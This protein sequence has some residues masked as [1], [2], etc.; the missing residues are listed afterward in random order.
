MPAAPKEDGLSRRIGQSVRSNSGPEFGTTFLSAQSEHWTAESDSTNYDTIPVNG[1]S[2][3]Q[4][5]YRA[6]FLA[7]NE[8]SYAVQGAGSLNVPNFTSDPRAAESAVPDLSLG[9]FHSHSSNQPGFYFNAVDASQQQDEGLNDFAQTHPDKED[10]ITSSSSSSKHLQVPRGNSRPASTSLQPSLALSAAGKVP[11]RPTTALLP[12]SL[13]VKARST[14]SSAVPGST[15]RPARWEKQTDSNERMSNPTPLRGTSGH[16]SADIGS[17]DELANKTTDSIS[18]DA[19][20]GS[21]DDVEVNGSEGGMG[22]EALQR[23]EPRVRADQPPGILQTG[24]TE[25]AQRTQSGLPAEKVFPIQIGSELFRL[26]GA[27]I[28]SD[29]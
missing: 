3:D 13:K 14:P 18:S 15:R 20:S 28:A 10:Y 6:P 4:A 25:R 11:Q 21:G 19:A 2:S 8:Q 23:A 29:G 17:R 7:F 9:S 16:R 1:Q 27:S 12:T 24:R 26:S 5:Q 22:S